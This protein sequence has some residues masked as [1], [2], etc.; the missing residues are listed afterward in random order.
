V[1]N[2][3]GGYTL[4]LHFDA[5]IA[6]LR[7]ALQRALDHLRVCL[8]ALE[9]AGDAPD[10]QL[11]ASFLGAVIVSAKARGALPGTGIHYRV[12]PSLAEPIESA[13]SWL[14]SCALRDVLAAFQLALE[15]S[16]LQAQFIN[17]A[18]GAE[19]GRIENAR[20]EVVNPI[21]SKSNE[22]A[23]SFHW[24]GLAAKLERL[25][26]AVGVPPPSDLVSTIAALTSLAKARNCLE[27]R[28]GIV[29]KPDVDNSDALVVRWVAM[30]MTLVRED[31]THEEARLGEDAGYVESAIL[32]QRRAV[33]RS[34]SLGHPLALTV[35]D[36]ND[37]CY[38]L[39]L[40]AADV[41]QALA[42]VAA[43]VGIGANEPEPKSE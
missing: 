27:H 7:V 13:R 23:K 15:E 19:D 5:P 4:T 42:G 18:R 31:G 17:L 3:G 16:F 41:Q 32:H 35:E 34:F 26:A 8:T 22:A 1:T 24:A 38:A 11:D 6:Q 2:A 10:Q 14:V 25:W 12:G 39:T 33:E 21:L 9:L 40:Y 20:P 28:Q 36:I 37:I 43:L 29:G 30:R